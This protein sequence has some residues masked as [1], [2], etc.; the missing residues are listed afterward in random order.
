MEPPH[1]SPVP[2]SIAKMGNPTLLLLSGLLS[3]TQA[4]SIGEHENKTRHVIVWRHSSSHQCSDWRTVTE[5]FPPQKGNP[6]RPPYSQRVS[7]D[8]ANNTLTVKP[9]ETNNGCWETTSQGINHPPTTIQYR[10]WNITT[11]PTIQTINITKMTV[12]EGEDFTLYGPVSETMSIIEW[13]FIK[14]VTPQFILQYYLSINSTIVYASYQGR[15]T[16]NPGKNTLTLKGA[17]T[18]DSGTYKST[19]NLDQVSAHTFRVEVTPIEKKEEATAETPASKPT[20]I[21]RVRAD[22]RSTALWVGL[23]LCILTVIPAL[24]GWYF[25]DRLCVPDPIIELE[26]PGQPHVTIHILKGPDDDCET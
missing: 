1:N 2:F 26:I 16:F 5:W 23:A 11:T 8:T 13:E 10:V 15:V 21:P 22:A 25:R 6:V 14:D 12:R 20:P 17:K 24:I 9:F 7:L 18:T 19:V 4:I 3:L